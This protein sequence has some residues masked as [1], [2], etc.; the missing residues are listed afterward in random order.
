MGLDVPE[1][2]MPLSEVGKLLGRRVRLLSSVVSIF[3]VAE[4]QKGSSMFAELIGNALLAVA[5]PAEL[6]ANLIAKLRAAR[7]PGLIE[8]VSGAVTLPL[9]TPFI[10]ANRGR[11]AREKALLK[12]R[13]DAVEPTAN[14]EVSE[15]AVYN[16]LTIN[17]T[18]AQTVLTD[19]DGKTVWIASGRKVRQ[20]FGEI[21]LL[22]LARK[23]VTEH[24][25]AALPAIQAIESPTVRPGWVLATG[26]INVVVDG[27]VLVLSTE[28]LARNA[29]F[30]YA[31]QFSVLP[32]VEYYPVY[33]REEYYR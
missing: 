19:E 14:L 9:A 15:A 32:T 6:V 29:A 3:I 21:A 17:R 2:G 22:D 8:I 20:A 24:K 18:A 4:R 16:G 12:A 10:I 31:H 23:I 27:K 1:L 5:T 13:L 7:T 30:R 25:L 28:E 11:V 33:S 26:V